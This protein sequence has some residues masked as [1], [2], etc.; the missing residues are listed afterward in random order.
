MR[1]YYLRDFLVVVS[2][3]CTPE[4]SNEST[5]GAVF[6]FYIIPSQRSGHS[7]FIMPIDHEFQLYCNSLFPLNILLGI[8]HSFG[9]CIHWDLHS[10]VGQIPI[11]FHLQ[12]LNCSSTFLIVVLKVTSPMHSLLCVVITVWYCSMQ[13][14][15]IRMATILLYNSII[16]QNSICITLRLGLTGNFSVHG[17]S[18]S[19]M[20][21]TKQNALINPL[22]GILSDYY[23]VPIIQLVDSI[24]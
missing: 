18:L 14:R 4:I 13:V 6:Q 15:A 7:L 16:E 20:T 17:M 2:L 21:G 22:G 1:V 11:Q 3:H 10:I 5:M 12:G 9:S 24:N 23:G 8:H 19:I